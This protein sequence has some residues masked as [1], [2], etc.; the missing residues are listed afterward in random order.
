[1]EQRR[2]RLGDIVDDYCPRERRITNHAVVAMIE[3]DVKQTRCTTCDADHEY[4]H[5]RVPPQRKKKEASALEGPFT[6]DVHV[7]ATPDSDADDA[8][9][10]ASLESSEETTA[11]AVTASGDAPS[12][13]PSLSAG[14]EDEESAERLDD[15]GPVHRRLIRATLPRPEG[16]LPERKETDFTVR[17]P[18][19]GGRFDHS[20]NGRDGNRPRHQRGGQG[21]YASGGQRQGQGGSNRTDG[22]RPGVPGNSRPA[23]R[24][25]GGGGQRRGGGGGGR[26]RGGR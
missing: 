3:D 22:N 20:G 13:A 17:Q 7:R 19:R 8:I 24:P 21:Q 11:D 18:S 5:A 25:G 6:E 16:Q 12:D 15:D 23:G 26:R 2:P 1:M 14:A 9:A 4:K 10:D